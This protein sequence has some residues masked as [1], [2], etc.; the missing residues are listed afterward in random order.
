MK[1]ESRLAPP[2]AGSTPQ[3]RLW[4]A[5]GQGTRR[6]GS[7]SNKEKLLSKPTPLTLQETAAE[8]VYI[9]RPLVHRILPSATIP[10]FVVTFTVFS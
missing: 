4:G 5:P 8:S 7:S 1:P 6:S 2:V 10:L 9:G 3:V